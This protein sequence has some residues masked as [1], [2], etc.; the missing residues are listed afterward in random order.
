[1]TVT[2]ILLSVCALLSDCNPSD[3]LDSS[4]AKK[5]LEDREEHDKIAREWTKRYAWKKPSNTNE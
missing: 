3:P 5:F 4:I 2:Q 1:M